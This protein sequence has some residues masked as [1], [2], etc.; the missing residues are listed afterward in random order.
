M[1]NLE[2]GLQ[3]L[4][5]KPRNL[6]LVGRHVKVADFGLVNSL[7]EL[8][9]NAPHAVQMGGSRRCTRRRKASSATLPSSAINIVLRSPTTSCWSA[10]PFAG[11]NF[12]QLALQHLQAEPDLGRLPEA[13]RAVVARALAKE[14]RTV[15]RPASRSSTPWKREKSAQPRRFRV[16]AASAKP[17]TRTDV[18]VL[19]LTS[20]PRGRASRRTP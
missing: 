11:K 17:A 9:G 8:S 13:D 1:L 12:R 19:N 5:V 15:S 3:H 4:D 7:A 2:H 10:P 18:H 6:F 20:T 14:P 16:G